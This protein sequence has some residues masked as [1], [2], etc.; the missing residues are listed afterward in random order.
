MW[1][2]NAQSWTHCRSSMN[3]ALVPF[4]T[5]ATKLND[6]N[7][8]CDDFAQRPLLGPIRPDY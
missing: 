7:W 3:E 6:G 5:A 8:I 2:I 4:R 1:K